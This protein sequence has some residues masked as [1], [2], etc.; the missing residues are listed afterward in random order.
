LK[1]ILIIASE[2]DDRLALISLLRGKYMIESLSHTPRSV[3]ELRDIEFDGIILSVR[4][5]D[6]SLDFCRKIMSSSLN[7]W[8]CIIDLEHKIQNP[9]EVLEKYA[10]LGYWGATVSNE[11]PPFIARCFQGHVIIHKRESRLDRFLG[12]LSTKRRKTQ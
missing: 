11:F 9:E 3:N 5:R 4:R 6:E 12:I 7:V 10:L 8:V 2:L 1:T